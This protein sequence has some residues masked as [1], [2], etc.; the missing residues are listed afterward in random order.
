VS[1]FLDAFRAGGAERRIAGPG[2][3]DNP[4]KLTLAVPHLD[5]R[6][7]RDFRGGGPLGNAMPFE[8]ASDPAAAGVA[9]HEPLQAE[10]APSAP[11][12][13]LVVERAVMA[14]HYAAP[15]SARPYQPGEPDA[16][17][18]GLLASYRSHR[19]TP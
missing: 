14:L 19:R 3:P 10:A 5:F 7:Y 12:D 17:R 8:A 6:D 9:V 15:A 4:E 16:L 13:D 11:D 2:R 18:D 1:R